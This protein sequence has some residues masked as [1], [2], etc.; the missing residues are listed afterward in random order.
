MA[1]AL[2]AG[3]GVGLLAALP[4]VLVLRLSGTSVA[5]GLA[6]VMLSFALYHAA[7]LAVYWLDSAALV[8]VAAVSV[9][10]FLAAVVTAA[11]HG[12]K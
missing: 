7:I 10:A 6:A 2:L 9:A 11:L 4:L 5:V 3:I 8:T 12:T 1:A